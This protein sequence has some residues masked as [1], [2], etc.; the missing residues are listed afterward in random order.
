MANLGVGPM[1]LSPMVR[2]NGLTCYGE[3][4]W[5]G[6][7]WVG[8]NGLSGSGPNLGPPFLG[9]EAHGCMKTTTKPTIHIQNKLGEKKDI[10]MWKHMHTLKSGVEVY[11]RYRIDNAELFWINGQI[12]GQSQISN[13]Q[14][15]AQRTDKKT[16][17]ISLPNLN[18]LSHLN[19][20]S[21]VAHVWQLSCA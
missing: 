16:P 20:Q 13:K 1:D 6:P 12:L 15:A 14:T 8:P 2:S 21:D 4:Q 17:S 5:A 7:L 3:A 19:S 10:K 18:L 11:Q 9:L